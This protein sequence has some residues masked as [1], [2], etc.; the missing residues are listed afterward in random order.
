MRAWRE[1]RLHISPKFDLQLDLERLFLGNSNHPAD[2]V[3]RAR[4]GE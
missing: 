2:E 4:D 1:E 3:V